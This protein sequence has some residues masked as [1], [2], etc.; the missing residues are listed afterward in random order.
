MDTRIDVQ[1]RPPDDRDPPGLLSAELVLID[2]ELAIRARAALADPPDTV[3][4][5]LLAA[6]EAAERKARVERA[7]REDTRRPVT[8]EQPAPTA[9]GYETIERP[10]P[11]AVASQPVI[12][13][14]ALHTLRR[15]RAHFARIGL[16]AAGIATIA[17]A[18]M[19]GIR[20]GSG[21]ANA[22][23]DPRGIGV[24]TEAPG[25]SVAGGPAEPKAKQPNAKQAEARRTSS[26]RASE[27]A[28]R[29]AARVAR[30]RTA[31]ASK[32]AG[33]VKA[34]VPS[35]SGTAR[36]FAWAPVPR[37]AS[38]YVEFFRGATRVFAASTDR[39]EIAVP[40]RWSFKGKAHSLAPGDYRWYV[41]PVFA[42]SGRA[43]AA[44]VQARL[45]VT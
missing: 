43:S 38:Y 31:A 23:A 34:A 40:K 15:S 22:V 5:L 32:K 39:A 41:W 35:P 21:D 28:A 2:P 26:T 7:A 16:A 44:S 13:Q 29:A 33:R 20:I 4:E 8:I 14:P 6:R 18:L 9:V 17:V 12:E 3:A 1:L 24:L 19:F 45:R 27:R 30:A 25:V 36:R 37:A 42:S 11:I 10:V